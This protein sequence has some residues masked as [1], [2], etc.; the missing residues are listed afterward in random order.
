VLVPFPAPSLAPSSSLIVTLLPK[1]PNFTWPT[2]YV[3]RP[4]R[5][6]FIFDPRNTLPCASMAQRSHLLI[7]SLTLHYAGIPMHNP[8]ALTGWQYSQLQP[9]VSDPHPLCESRSVLPTQR[10]H[11]DFG[12]YKSPMSHLTMSD[13]TRVT[14]SS[15]RTHPMFG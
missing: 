14:G 12:E 15:S 13:C 5:F 11:R 6:F 10:I 8:R 2:D 1:L 7:F 4:S 9:L 3:T